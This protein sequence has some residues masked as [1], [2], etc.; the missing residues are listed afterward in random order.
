MTAIV[1][2][3]DLFAIVVLTGLII[4]TL[5]LTGRWMNGRQRAKGP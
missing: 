1:P 2:A 4:G 3:A 5:L